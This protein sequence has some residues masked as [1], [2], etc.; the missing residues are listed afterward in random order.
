MNISLL[1]PEI[2]T[3]EATRQKLEQVIFIGIIFVLVCVVALVLLVFANTYERLQ[4]GKVQQQKQDIQAKIDREYQKYADLE[5]KIESA[6]S[7]LKVA[8]GSTPDWCLVLTEVKNSMPANLILTSSQVEQQQGSTAPSNLLL[9][10]GNAMDLPTLTN[11]IDILKETTTITN[12]R[13]Q[14][15]SLMEGELGA[16]PLRYQY[17]V[18]VEMKLS[19]GYLPAWEG[20]N[21]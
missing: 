10:K 15:T 11:W 2:K 1:P 21:K 3:Q 18:L 8:M 20:S 6:D 9:I 16:G 7:T 4:I 14:Y 17:Q 19:E 13:F 12:P 5:G